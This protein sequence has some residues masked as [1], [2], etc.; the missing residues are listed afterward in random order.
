MPAVNIHG[1][2]PPY[3]LPGAISP[4]NFPLLLSLI[5]VVPALLAGC[6]ALIK[7]SEISPRF[8]MPVIRSIAAVPELADV[9][10]IMPGDGGV[11]WH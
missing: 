2:T 6:S 4:W 9:L 3:Q 7:P 10:A 1:E 5:D 8:A 11:Q